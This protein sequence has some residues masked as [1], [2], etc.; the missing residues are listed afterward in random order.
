MIRAAAKNHE[1]V[2]VVVDP[3]DYPRLLEVG[4][5]P[6]LAAFFR[7]SLAF[8]ALSCLPHVAPASASPQASRPI[9]RNPFP[10]LPFL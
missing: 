10:F 9:R 6:F 3:A 8:A 7:S 4:S 5:Y 2:H 1:H